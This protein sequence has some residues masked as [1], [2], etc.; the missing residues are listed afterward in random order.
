VPGALRVLSWPS[1]MT[2]WK[3]SFFFWEA[4]LGAKEE[5]GWPAPGESHEAHAL[6]EVAVAGQ[7]R[8]NFLDERPLDREGEFLESQSASAAVGR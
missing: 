4:E 6:F 3:E 5:F 7:Q 8:Q 1:K 2:A